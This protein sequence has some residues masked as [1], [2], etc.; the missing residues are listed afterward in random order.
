MNQIG[1]LAGY[2]CLHQACGLLAAEWPSFGECI[3]FARLGAAAALVSA[4]RKLL[5]KCQNRGVAYKRGAQAALAHPQNEGAEH[6][7]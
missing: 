1:E 4:A 7:C 5:G 2:F 3:R 6:R